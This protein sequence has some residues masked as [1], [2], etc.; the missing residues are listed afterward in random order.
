[1]ILYPA[2][3]LKQGQCV[4]LL[5]GEMD[6]AT[7]FSDTP[8]DQARSFEEA[9]FEWLHLVDL[10]GAFAGS[11]QNVAAVEAILQ[12]VSIPAQLG[13]GIREIAH[14]ER[15]LEAGIKRIILGTVALTNPTLVREA[16]KLFPGQVAVGIDARNGFVATEGWAST[17][18]TTALQLAEMLE[19]AGACAF[20]YTDISRDG[21]MRGP[22]LEATAALA[23]SVSVPV[24]LSGGMSSLDDVKSVLAHETDGIAGIILGRALYEGAIVPKDALSL[25]N[26]KNKHA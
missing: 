5:H 19:D 10:D 4:R 17:S 7:I 3:D 21:A 12:R 2:I 15:W 24:I 1:M 23:R 9:G 6:K 11:S 20:I 25:T 18:Q 22:N 14:I 16:C 13:G 8:A 26:G